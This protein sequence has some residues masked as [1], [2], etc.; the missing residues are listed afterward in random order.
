MTDI[1]AAL[2]LGTTRTVLAIGESRPG[3]RPKVLCHAEINSSGVRKSRI[4]DIRQ[5]SASI[6]SVI[7]EVVRRQ[8]ESG[9]RLTL[10]NAYLVV[11]GS[12]VRADPYRATRAIEGQRVGSRDIEEVLKSAQSMP[13]SKDREILEVFEQSYSLDSMN[14]IASPK[15]MSGRILELDTLQIHAEADRVNDARTAAREAHIE[16]EEPLFAATCAA[17]AVLDAAERRDGVLVL[18]LGGGSTGCAV[19]ADG[20]LAGAAALGVGGDHLTNDIAYAFQTT[21]SQSETLKRTEAS[22]IPGLVKNASERVGVPGDSPL[23]EARTVSRKALDTV[24]NIRMK[25]IAEMVREFLEE[26]GLLHRLHAGVVLTGGGASL[27]G[28][29]VLM[30]RELGMPARIGIPSNIDGLSDAPAPASFAAVAGALI[31]AHRN[32]GEN[33]SL[34]G[35]LMGR[36]FG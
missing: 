17:D 15:G 12:H 25:E 27:K 21:Q 28:A 11:S 8:G 31:Y 13:L 3:E 36:F 5:A 2:E 23:M 30:G 9:D 24:V 33:E 10:E 32:A 26:K 20:Y 22:A 6:R 14:G 29:D 7:R 1:H 34:F 19:Y 18:D 35:K 4:Q 16:L